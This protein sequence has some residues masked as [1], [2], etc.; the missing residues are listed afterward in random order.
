MP[1]F[2]SCLLM[3]HCPKQET[4]SG[5]RSTKG[6]DTSYENDCEGENFLNN[7]PVY[8]VRLKTQTVSKPNS[9][10]YCFCLMGPY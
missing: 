1:L 9:L 5:L 8:L 4:W 7:N 2:A 10:K 3:S 6:V